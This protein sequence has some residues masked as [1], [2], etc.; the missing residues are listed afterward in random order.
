MKNIL[1]STTKQIFET[2]TL[3]QSVHKLGSDGQYERSLFERAAVS[4][5]CFLKLFIALEEFLEASF[6][7]Y[8]VGETSTEQ[9][10]PSKFAEPI[11]VEHAQKMLIGT[12]RF[13]DWSTPNTIVKYAELYFSDGEPFKTPLSGSLSQLQSMKTVRNSTAHLSSTTRAALDG[14]YSRWT[15]KPSSNVSAYDIL[16][17]PSASQGDTFYAVSEQVVSAIVANIANRS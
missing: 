4:E 3:L 6:I 7:H 9:W 8:L 11:S 16:M 15:G 2:R 13:V 1:D 14:L 10:R 17:A 12:Q 5:T